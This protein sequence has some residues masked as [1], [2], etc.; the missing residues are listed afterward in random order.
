MDWHECECFIPKMNI[1]LQGVSI[2]IYN[3]KVLFRSLGPQGP[4]GPVGPVGP[5]EP[6]RPGGTRWDP[7]NI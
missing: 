4:V 3:S 5:N 1:K 7:C 6:V 2:N